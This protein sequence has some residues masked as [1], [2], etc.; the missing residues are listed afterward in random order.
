MS[1]AD[2]HIS[3]ANKNQSVLTHLAVD[4]EKYSEWVATV[5]FYKALHIVESVFV[6]KGV[7]NTSNHVD[8][9]LKLKRDRR[10]H[11]IFEHYRPMWVASQIARYLEDPAG[12]TA[13]SSFRDYLRPDEVMKQIVR[14]RLRQV[15]ASA[16]RL[17][18]ELASKLQTWPADGRPDSAGNARGQG[19]IKAAGDPGS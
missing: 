1:S 19:S 3:L 15:E 12:P 5:A 18:P 6:A 8:R 11:H 7:G 10:F 9:L 13:Y 2:S 16:L 4:L 14:H 17:C